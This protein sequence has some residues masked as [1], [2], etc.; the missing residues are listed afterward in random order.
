MAFTQALSWPNILVPWAA[1]PSPGSTDFQ[2]RAGLPCLEP[3]PP[4]TAEPAVLQVGEGGTSHPLE[5][6]GSIL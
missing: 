1:S 4:A 6:A 3:L 2:P 5:V